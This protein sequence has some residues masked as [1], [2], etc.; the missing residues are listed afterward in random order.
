M[1]VTTTT[2]AA[3]AARAEGFDRI[4]RNH[5]LYWHGVRQQQR[6]LTVHNTTKM[7]RGRAAALSV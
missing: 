6:K 4:L 7:L 5:D 1:T 2:Q 3:T